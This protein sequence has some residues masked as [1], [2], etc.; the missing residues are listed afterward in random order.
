MVENENK[1]TG[2]P[3]SVIPEYTV[4]TSLD[5]QA[6]ANLSLLLTGTFYGR[7]EPATR[8]MNNDPKCTADCD[9]TAVLQPR[10]AYD[11]WSLSARYRITGSWDKP[12][13][14]LVE[15]HEAT[16]PGNDAPAALEEALP[17]PAGTVPPPA[18]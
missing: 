4:N 6:A 16:T 15:K 5:W 8:D 2:Q 11:L 12:E 10:G 1:T 9:G 13:M 3:L 18:D 17:A 7:Q 14:T